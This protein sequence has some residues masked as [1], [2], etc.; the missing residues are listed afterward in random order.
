MYSFSPTLSEISL[1]KIAQ[2]GFNSS[3]GS[4]KTLRYYTTEYSDNKNIL[5][6]PLRWFSIGNIGVGVL[7]AQYWGFH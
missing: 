3:L 7:L 2:T 4:V 5:A 6:Q 1:K